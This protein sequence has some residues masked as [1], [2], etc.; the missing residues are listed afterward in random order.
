MQ[1]I[2]C[3]YFNLPKLVSGRLTIANSFLCC[4]ISNTF[5]LPQSRL[6]SYFGIVSHESA[7]NVP[8]TVLG[9]MYYGVLIFFS[10]SLDPW[11]SLSLASVAMFTSVFLA[12]S[13][14]VLN[15]LCILCWATHVINFLLLYK[16]FF[17]FNYRTN[18]GRK[19][20]S[21]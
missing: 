3:C 5:A 13:M 1:V 18:G 8:N 6:L 16:L 2:N 14:I 11:I 10:S 21:S 15:E 17:S 20:K 7:F 19:T 4:S 12:Y 9:L